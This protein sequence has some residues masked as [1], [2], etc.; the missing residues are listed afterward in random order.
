MRAVPS[1]ASP[2]ENGGADRIRRSGAD[3][4]TVTLRVPG[5]WLTPGIY[6]IEVH[7]G[8]EGVAARFALSVRGR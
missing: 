3:A 5:V 6:G 8:T 1:N 2:D 4:A 7:A